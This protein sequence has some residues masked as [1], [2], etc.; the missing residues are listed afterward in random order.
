MPRHT[1][2][3][4][5]AGRFG[6]ALLSAPVALSLG[7]AAPVALPGVA[8][9]ESLTGVFLAGRHAML[10]N[11]AEAAARYFD[12]AAQLSPRQAEFRER[13]TFYAAASGDLAAAEAHAAKLLELDPENKI[14]QT[15]AAA[16][17]LRAGR[18]AEARS[19]LEGP[20]QGTAGELLRTLLKGWIAAAEGDRDA[21]EGAFSRTG[22]QPFLKLVGRYH[23]ALLALSAGDHA[24]AVD[25]FE[26]SIA[27]VGRPTARMTL[28]YAAALQG[29]GRSDD[30]RERIEAAFAATPTEP[31]IRVAREALEQGAPIPAPVSAPSDGAAEAFYDVGYA[32]AGEDE[33]QYGLFLVR[34]G[35]SLRPDF[36]EALL[37]AGELQDRLDQHEAAAAIFAQIAP[38]SPHY[39]AAQVS[40]AISLARLDREDEGL[41]ALRRLAARSPE[42]PTVHFAMGDFF[43]RNDAFEACARAYEAGLA[44]LE[45]VSERYWRSYFRLGACYER[46]GDWDRAEENLQ[47]ALELRPNQADVLNYLGY[48][49]VEQGRRLDEARA[50]IEKAVAASPQS[51]YIVDSLGWVLYRTGD[52][53][54]AVVQ[55]ERAAELEPTEPVI[56]DH[57]GDALWRVGRKNEAR[58]HWSRALSFDPEEKDRLRIERKLEVGLDAV[59]DE[60]SALDAGPNRAEAAGEPAAT[61]PTARPAQGG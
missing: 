4:G 18:T 58:F 40:R 43:Q 3:R 59:L 53:E 31:M 9:A 45:S 52:F 19:L 16:Q 56:N 20:G 30:A 2:R 51:G 37:L 26:E 11:D 29:A 50:L 23:A 24:A 38:A 25:A 10:R 49:L 44:R 27:L 35:A 54:G 41:E 46:S 55:L 8:A 17:A 34:L 61:K 47:K 14:A 28:G 6:A 22:D 12:R 48:S 32:L 57:L 36:D 21:A 60:E 1:I 33:E 42:D 15:V 13:A 7:L 5:A 39:G